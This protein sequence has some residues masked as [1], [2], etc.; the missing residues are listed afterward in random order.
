MYGTDS[1][2]RKLN[3]IDH[4]SEEDVSEI[5]S[6]RI[7]RAPWPLADIMGYSSPEIRNLS[8]NR[9]TW[10]EK[11]YL[12]QQAD[13]E[14]KENQLEEARILTRVNPQLA[15]TVSLGIRQS[16]QKRS[17]NDLFG[18][19]ASQFVK[20]VSGCLDVLSGRLPDRNCTTKPQVSDSMTP[21]IASLI[22]TLNN[23]LAS[24]GDNGDRL[25]SDTAPLIAAATQLESG[26]HAL[27]M[28]QGCFSD[29]AHGFDLRTRR[30]CR[31]GLLFHRLRTLAGAHEETF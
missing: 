9:L 6:K 14:L 23:G 1:I 2:L 20:P 15:H 24:Q 25:L 19:R 11:E 13:Q 7:Q 17:Y 30:L 22:E 16:A 12:H 29:F 4:A 8:A 28:P 21:E 5:G 26:E 27:A 31:Q 10:G 18:H 3:T